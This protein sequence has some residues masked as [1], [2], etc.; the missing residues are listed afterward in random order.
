MTAMSLALAP[1]SHAT[2]AASWSSTA[3]TLPPLG[4]LDAYI[5]AVNRIP[6]LSADEERECA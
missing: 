3:L 5:S 1:A 6:M 2:P 4:N